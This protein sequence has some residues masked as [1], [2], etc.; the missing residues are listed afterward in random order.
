MT[1]RLR[2]L[3]V[4]AVSG[5]VAK[6]APL[7]GGAPLE[8]RA[9]AP[10]EPAIGEAA[11]WDGILLDVGAEVPAWDETLRSLQRGFPGVPVL[12]VVRPDQRERGVQAV[13]DGVEE[14]L[15]AGETTGDDVDRVLRSAR[16]ARDLRLDIPG[17]GGFCQRLWGRLNEWVVIVGRGGQRLYVSPS[18]R[19]WLGDPPALLGSDALAGVQPPDQERVRRFFA[20]AL[21]RGLEGAVVFRVLLPS[22]EVRHVDVQGI[23]VPG[24]DGVPRALALLG[25]DVTHQRQVEADL[26]EREVFYR[27]ISENMSDLVAV[28]DRQGRRLYNSPSYRR[29]FGGRDPDRAS[30][31]FVE[32]HPQDRERIRR[33]FEA[34]VATGEGQRAEFR[35]VLPDGSIRFLESVGSVIRDDSGEVTKVLVVSRDTTDRRAAEEALARERN[36]LRTLVDQLP[37]F[38]YVKDREGRF[39]LNNL[40]H[41]RLAGVE[42]PAVLVGRTDADVFPPGLASQYAADDGAVVQRGEAVLDR[43]EPVCDPAGR[44]RWVLTSKLPLRD[45]HGQVA[46]LVGISRDITERRRAEHALRESEERLELVVRGSR[47]G[48]WDWDLRT[49]E[50]YFSARWKSMLGY[51][52]TEVPNTFAGW[53]ALLHP[54]DLGR[55]MHTLQRYFDGAT[56]TYELEHRLR[57][58]DGNYRWILARGVVLRDAE[59]RPVR[60]AGTHVDLTE[61]KQTEE[62]LRQAARWESVTTLAAGVAHEVK[63]P[64]QTILLG[65]DFLAHRPMADEPDVAGLLASMHNAARQADTIIRNLRDYAVQRQPQFR[66]CDLNRLIRETL[67]PMAFEF[68]RLGVA[69][70]EHLAADL[71]PVWLDAEQFKQVC[72]TVFRNALDAMAGVEGGRR[73]R[74]ATRRLAEGPGTVQGAPPVGTGIAGHWVAME[75]EDTGPGVAAEDLPR[76]FDLFFSTKPAGQGIGIGLALARRVLEA[77]GGTIELC[78]RPEGGARLTVAIPERAPGADGTAF[79]GPPSSGTHPGGDT[80]GT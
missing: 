64:L 21:E 59:G 9:W 4:G 47:D 28:V 7:P 25:R 46:G 49:N 32:I 15:V 2:L 62:R 60:M 56:A 11:T 43:E 69:R 57:H 72:W 68:E 42:D 70:V 18:H 79:G 19:R 55:A 76:V 50:V 22:G 10:E 41:A 35:F 77:H 51:A 58:K 23:P 65:V 45:A 5:E 40:A 78:N 39:V 75:V 1:A 6:A 13:R 29:L 67:A 27:H 48:I 31:S 14:F 61:R 63:N 73:L 38:I 33:I 36:L 52:E 3:C 20:D 37:D 54:E 30:N 8:W 26:R 12:A 53:R 66:T 17:T 71:P 24:P 44:Q 74:V 80:H 16:E 34:T